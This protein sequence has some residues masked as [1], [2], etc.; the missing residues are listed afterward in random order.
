LSLCKASLAFAENMIE[1]LHR[2]I[3]ER[4]FDNFRSGLESRFRANGLTYIIRYGEPPSFSL[5]VRLESKVRI[6]EL[7]AW[8]SG[9]CEVQM[10]EFEKEGVESVHCQLRS[11]QDFHEYLAEVFRFVVKREFDID[12][13][14]KRVCDEF[15][16]VKIEQLKVSHPGA[17][18]DG[19]WF[20]SRENKKGDVQ[21]ESSTYNVPFIVESTAS[22]KCSTASTIDEAV[23]AVRKFFSEP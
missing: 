20:F 18:D 19:L 5:F 14:K 17:D 12:I 1:S 16:D 8:E 7:C 11:D 2:L 15:P 23:E 3:S 9:D 13:I 4:G 22:V 10:A 6:G 21:L